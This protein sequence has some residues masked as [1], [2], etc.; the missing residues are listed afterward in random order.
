MDYGHRPLLKGVRL[1]LDAPRMHDKATALCGDINV[2]LS[3]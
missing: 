2:K 3:F 1:R